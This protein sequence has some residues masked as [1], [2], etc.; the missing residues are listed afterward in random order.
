MYM[1]G[2]LP[3]NQI[4]TINNS[5]NDYKINKEKAKLVEIEKERKSNEEKILYIKEVIQQNIEIENL[6]KYI[7]EES[8]FNPKVAKSFKSFYLKKYITDCNNINVNTENLLAIVEAL[9]D[10]CLV[11]KEQIDKKVF[12]IL[13]NKPLKIKYNTYIDF[14]CYIDEK[15]NTKLKRLKDIKGIISNNVE[16]LRII[17]N[18][19]NNYFNTIF[20]ENRENTLKD[21]VDAYYELRVKA[22]N[23][24]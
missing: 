19:E 10:N 3:K 17:E 2:L 13:L 9:L 24:S 12:K 11:L 23:H 15:L 22:F 7:M 4:Q 14:I 5:I 8:N 18:I 1:D 20:E 21:A 6:I 16:M